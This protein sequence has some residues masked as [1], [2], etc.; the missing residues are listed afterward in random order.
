LSK[1]LGESRDDFDRSKKSESAPNVTWGGG[2]KPKGEVAEVPLFWGELFEVFKENS[3]ETKGKR[4]DDVSTVWVSLPKNIGC[5]T[6]LGK[7]QQE[8]EITLKYGKNKF[9]IWGKYQGG[10]G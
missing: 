9:S 7:I 1:T 4:K 5:S 8:E 2:G 3:F 6:G 10:L